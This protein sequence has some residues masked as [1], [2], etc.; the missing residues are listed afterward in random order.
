MVVTLRAGS[1]L[2]LVV[3]VEDLLE[4]DNVEVVELIQSRMSSSVNVTWSASGGGLDDADRFV[5]TAARSAVVWIGRRLRSLYNAFVGPAK[6]RA[7]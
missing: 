1:Q 5:H 3:L 6:G 2:A 7:C 4:R